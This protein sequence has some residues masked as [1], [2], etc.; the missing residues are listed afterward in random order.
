MGKAEKVLASGLN[1]RVCVYVSHEDSDTAKGAAA[2]LWARI[3]DMFEEEELDIAGLYS[4][5]QEHRYQLLPEEVTEEI[6]RDPALFAQ[7]ALSR[8][9]S[10]FTLLPLDNLEEDPFFID[11]L[12]V[13]S[14]LSDHGGY[15]QDATAD[16]R[17]MDGRWYVTLQGTLKEE[18]LDFMDTKGGVKRI[19]DEGSALEER[20]EGVKVNYSGLAFHSYESAASAQREILVIA[21]VSIA[22]ILLLFLILLGSV[23][24]IGLFLLST[25]FS[26]VPAAAALVVFFPEVHV[27]TLIFGTTLIGTSIDYAIHFYLSYAREKDAGRTVSK[28]WRNL[29]ASFLSTA[30]CYLLLFLSPYGILHQVAVFSFSGLLGSYLSALGLFP[31]V[32]SPKM[33][34]GKA[35]FL[36]LPKA[37]GHRPLLLP[38][39]ILSLALLLAQAGKLEIHNDIS[40]LYSMSGRLLEGEGIASRLSGGASLTYTLIEGDDE[41]EAREIEAEYIGKLE[42]LKGEGVLDSYISPGLF[43]PT[44]ERQRQSFSSARKLLPYLEFVSDAL[45]LENVSSEKLER[46]MEALGYGDWLSAFVPGD[47]DGKYYIAV[48]LI[49]VSDDGRVRE[50][51]N[52]GARYFLKAQE[53][54]RQLDELTRVMFRIFSLALVFMAVLLLALYRKR[55]LRIIASP[56]IVISLSLAAALLAGLSI[57]FFFAVALL[58]VMGLGIDYMVFSSQK[59]EKPMLAVTL[60]YLTTA[61]SFGSLA[62]SSFTPVHIFGLTVLIGISAAFLTALLSGSTGRKG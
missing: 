45:A 56:L 9:F 54:N 36:R 28:L 61:L 18:N 25:F 42:A 20:Y 58:L 16:M 5:Y 30:L 43:I 2:S 10:P 49:G 59:G 27:F 48:L 44:E 24:V 14:F 55:G 57:E 34:S 47:I 60:S 7:E 35:L 3:D 12:M 62:L 1:S 37:R 46:E 51:D 19:F 39:L 26:F 8:V 13:R 21:T 22:L 33:V 11:E 32:L 40:S 31:L 17:E 15:F 41:E 29:T 4:V 53:V 52:D 38:L 23:H 50:L 6:D